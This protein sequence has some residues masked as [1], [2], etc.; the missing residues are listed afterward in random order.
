MIHEL[1]LI[2]YESFRILIYNGSKWTVQGCYTSRIEGMKMNGRNDRKWTATESERSWNQRY[3]FRNRPLWTGR[4]RAS[5]LNLS[6]RTIYFGRVFNDRPLLR[7]VHFERFINDR[8][9]STCVQWPS[10][11]NRIYRRVH[12]EPFLKDH[13]IRPSFE[14]PSTLGQAW[15]TVH[16]G[17]ASNDRPLWTQKCL[18]L[19]FE[20]LIQ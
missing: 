20:S 14:W 13:L 17:P 18:P 16:F 5:F 19:V 15:R 2:T 6:W 11:F 9:L 1:W 3:Q 12:F 10:T 7:I 8:L 4:R